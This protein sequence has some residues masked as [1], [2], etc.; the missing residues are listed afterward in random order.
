MSEQLKLC[1]FCG[2]KPDIALQLAILS[3]MREYSI[4]CSRCGAS[5]IYCFTKQAAIKSWNICA[6]V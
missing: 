5:S 1:P 4:V 2:S 3:P 6:E